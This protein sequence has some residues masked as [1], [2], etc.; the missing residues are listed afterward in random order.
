MYP[1]AGI[2]W[3]TRLQHR[4]MNFQDLNLNHQVVVWLGFVE[5]RQFHRSKFVKM[6][7]NSFI[8]NNFIEAANS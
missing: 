2:N 5:N 6:A 4:N 8:E 7:E 1:N 3:M